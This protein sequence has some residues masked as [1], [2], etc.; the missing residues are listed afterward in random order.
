V[1][2]SLGVPACQRIMLTNDRAHFRDWAEPGSGNFIDK[3]AELSIFIFV[4]V[5]VSLD[6]QLNLAF[7]LVH[8]EDVDQNIVIF[9]VKSVLDPHHFHNFRI[10]DVN[11]L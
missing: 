3:M 6:R 8:P 2:L 4:N 9:L 1:S 5:D 10:F 11:F 7:D